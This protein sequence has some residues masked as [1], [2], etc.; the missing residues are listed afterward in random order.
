V[1]KS[2]A[3]LHAGRGKAVRRAI[4][5]VKMLGHIIGG[6]KVRTIVAPRPEE[7]MNEGE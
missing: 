2:A 4:S 5:A 6:E 3:K 7:R 1:R